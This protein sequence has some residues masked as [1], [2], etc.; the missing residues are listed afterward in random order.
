M[1][2]SVNYGESG[3]AL[4]VLEGNRKIGPLRS[5]MSN[6]QWT[7]PPFVLFVV[8]FQQNAEHECPSGGHQPRETA[9]PDAVSAESQTPELKSHKS[10]TELSQ[11]NQE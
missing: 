8:C 7:S 4:G 3:V 1:F 2:P 5:H 11:K 10:M 9:A 6:V